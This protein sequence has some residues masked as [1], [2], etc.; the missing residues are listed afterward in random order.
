MNSVGFPWG[1]AGKASASNVGDL[2]S[3][4]GLGRS[5]GEGNGNP[6]Q[7]CCLEN[8][9]ARGA[10]WATFHGVA[11]SRT[12][13]SD[14]TASQPMNSVVILNS[15]TSIGVNTGNSLPDNVCGLFNIS[16]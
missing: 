3:I 5:H 6:L 8:P 4:P 14:L 16:T 10:Q 13:L 15:L 1:S 12:R 9:V 11:K 7:Y 2:H